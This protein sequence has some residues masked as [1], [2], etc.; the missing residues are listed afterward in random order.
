MI[1]EIRENLDIIVVIGLAL[2]G[3]HIWRKMNGHPSG[4]AK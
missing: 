2:L 4:I 1:S 3:Y